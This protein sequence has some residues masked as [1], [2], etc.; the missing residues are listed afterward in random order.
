MVFRAVS[1]STSAAVGDLRITCWLF[2]TFDEEQAFSCL[3]ETK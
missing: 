3:K 1:L 2:R